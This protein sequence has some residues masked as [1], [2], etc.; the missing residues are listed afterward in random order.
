MSVDPTVCAV[1]H[2]LGILDWDHLQ[3]KYTASIRTDSE[4]QSAVGSISRPTSPTY[5]TI[6]TVLEVTHRPDP[7]TPVD[8]IP[9]ML[10]DVFPWRVKSPSPVCASRRRTASG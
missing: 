1:R 10:A 9:G 8:A 5:L 4:T 6:A 7:M 3:A 2:F